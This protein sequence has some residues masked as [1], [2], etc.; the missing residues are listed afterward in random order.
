MF[1][2]CSLE[3]LTRILKNNQFDMEQKNNVAAAV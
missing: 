2:T 1:T 3:T